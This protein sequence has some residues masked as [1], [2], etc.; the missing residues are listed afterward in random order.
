MTFE[1]AG[2]APRRDAEQPR[3][4]SLLQAVVPVLVLVVLIVLAV[5]LY[6]GDLT[7]GPVQVALILCAVVAGL[8]GRWNGHSMES[9]SKAAVDSISTAM[10]AIFILLAVGS[11]IGTWNMSGTV[12]TMVHIGIRFLDPD[13]FYLASALVCGAVALGIGSAWT[14]IGTLGVA[15]V[16]IATAIG[17]SPLVTAGAII[18]G[19]YFG[20][21]MSP[22]SETTNLAPAVAGTDLYTHIRAML[23][24]T[25]PSIV[26]ALVLFAALGLTVEP[27]PAFDL[28]AALDAIERVFDVGLLSLVPLLVVIV[29]AVRRVPPTI[30]ILSG[31][32]AGGLTAVILQPQVVL[33]FVDEPDLAQPLAMLKGVWSAMATGF[34]LETGLPR[35]DALVTGGGMEGMLG[36][37]WLILAALA[38]GGI[39]EHTGSLARLIEPLLRRA[40]S[41]RSLLVTTGLTAIGLNVVA[42][43]QYMAIVLTGR[44]YRRPFEKEGIAPQTLSRQ[45]EDTATVTSPLVPWNS[46]GAYVAATLGIA[47][48]SYLPYCFFNLVNPVVSFA[49]A[50]LGRA[51]VRVE[52]RV[53]GGTGPAELRIHGVGGRHVE[54]PGIPGPG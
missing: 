50:L 51:I 1:S 35:L 54:S 25:V 26:I 43:D 2:P 7:A 29:M 15:L 8:I 36:T 22:L 27:L 13:W 46:C 14:V 30:T 38:F 3:A 4:P 48:F 53:E 33:D 16:A 19:A 44:M 32:L 39:M 17:V 6:G 34:S 49:L 41:A 23:V 18:S 5:A 10:G 24:T 11:L 42:A 21:K 40:R 12:A 37:V 31:A 47:T 45:V 28:T 20:D 9:L 52:P